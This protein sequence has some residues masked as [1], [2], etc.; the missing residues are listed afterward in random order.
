MNLLWPDLSCEF[1]TEVIKTSCGID[2]V[3]PYS[4]EPLPSAANCFNIL[5]ATDGI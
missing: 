5:R 4:I 2:F 1:S 3:N